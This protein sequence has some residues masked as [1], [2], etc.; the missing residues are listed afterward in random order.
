MWLF[1]HLMELVTLRMLLPSLHMGHYC[2]KAP[3]IFNNPLSI[4]LS[5]KRSNMQ[6]AKKLLKFYY[7]LND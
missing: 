4:L 3:I 7:I 6:A 2:W 5:K 1:R